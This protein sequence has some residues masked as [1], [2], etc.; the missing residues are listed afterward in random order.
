MLVTVTIFALLFA[1]L[2]AGWFQ[3]LRAQERL[4]DAVEKLQQQQQLV[5]SLRQLMS[6]IAN[7]RGDR[8]VTF[9]G[10]R[11][12]FVAESTASLAP[13]YGSA[14]IATSL[15]IEG[16]SPDLRLHIEHPGLPGAIYPWRLQLAELRYLDVAG[17]AHEDWPPRNSTFG[18]TAKEAPA[19]P[20]LLQLTLQFGPQS[21]PMTVL[22]A[23]RASAWQLVEPA[24]LFGAEVE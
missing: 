11:S 12:G 18:T 6:E 5:L 17:V 23:P 20:A 9:T 1:V 21:R 24:T 22:V 19:L 10:T 3:A 2:M 15:Q 14:P 16:N 8:G 13:G 7:P 4:G